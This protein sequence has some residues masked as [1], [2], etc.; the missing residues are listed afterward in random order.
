MLSQ[1]IKLIDFYREKIHNTIMDSIYAYNLFEN[2]KINLRNREA[3]QLFTNFVIYYLIQ[4]KP[5]D[6]TIKEVFVAF[7]DI[8]REDNI[9]NNP[10]MCIYEYVDISCLRK[11]LRGVLKSLSRSHPDL[12]FLGKRD[13]FM[14]NPDLV[15]QVFHSIHQFRL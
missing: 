12:I 9:F 11:C 1:S 5:A 14:T 7:P 15:A 3:K 13:T 6:P 8:L 2:G 10:N 4:H